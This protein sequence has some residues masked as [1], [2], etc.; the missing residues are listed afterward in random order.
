MKIEDIAR[1]A[2][3]AKG[4]VSKI[5]NGYPNI[6]DKLREKVK[7][8]IEENN[9][10]PNNS[11]RSLAGKKNKII[12]LFVYDE[13][14]ISKSSF[15]QSFVGMVIDECEKKDFSVLVSIL[16]SKHKI[17]NVRKYFDS[18]A[19]NGAIMIGMKSN[20]EEIDFLIEN[21][22]KISLIDYKDSCEIANTILVN[23]NNFTGAKIATKYLIEKGC[24]DLLHI[25]GELKK[26]PGIE[27]LRGF[28]ETCK[29]E[30]KKYTV[31]EGNFDGIYAKEV[32]EKYI[33]ESKSIPEGIFCSNDE[34]AIEIM[35][36][37]KTLD[38]KI[39]KDIRILGFDNILLASYM[40][41]KLS[42]V[43]VEMKIM[44]KKSVEY[45]IKKIENLE[46]KKVY[47][48]EADVKIIERES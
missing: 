22:Y 12:G 2:G 25:T 9:F 40:V 13:G 18:K 10:V 1:E 35:E 39:G 11:A 29:K 17:K 20:V 23:S 4:T 3:V 19:I 38:V 8:I 46:D 32:F 41:P 21:K 45:L 30:N 48:Y 37:L 16:N 44:A 27:R 36:Y 14:E 43:N 7:K 15:F 28:E 26:F 33:N 5:I 42:T 47:K 24:K 6:S 31:L 34:S